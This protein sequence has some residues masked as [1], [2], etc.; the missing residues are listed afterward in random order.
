MWKI[1]GRV[2]FDEVDI[3]LSDGTLARAAVPVVHPP[4]IHL[5]LKKLEEGCS[6]EDAM[7]VC[8]PGVLDQIMKWK[9][10]VAA[11]AT[12]LGH[13]KDEEMMETNLKVA[14]ATTLIAAQCVEVVVAMGAERDHLALVVS[15]AEMSGHLAISRL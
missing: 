9:V 7:A 4:A 3:T 5:V 6:I 11:T 15:S 14:S 1:F 8:E 12:S 10:V 2:F 13:R